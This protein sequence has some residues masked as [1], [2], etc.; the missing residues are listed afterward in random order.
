MTGV[1]TPSNIPNSVSMPTVIS[2]RKNITDH[3]DAKGILLMASV[4]TTKASP[5]PAGNY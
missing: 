1:T 5:V 3:N 2:M 4:K